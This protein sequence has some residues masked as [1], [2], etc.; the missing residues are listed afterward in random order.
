MIADALGFDLDAEIRS[1][2][3]ISVATAPIESPIGT[4]KPGQ[5]AAQRFT[6]VCRA[7]PGIKTYLD[8]PLV[9]GR[10]APELGTRAGGH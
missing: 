10:A 9:T 5:V 2:H 6:Y 8:L 3:E 1:T 7:G 4:I